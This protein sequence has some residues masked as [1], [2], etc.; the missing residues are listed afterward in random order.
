MYSFHLNA[1]SWILR[2]CSGDLGIPR[3][4]CDILRLTASGKGTPQ[5]GDFSPFNASDLL[6]FVAS[7]CFL[8]V[9]AFIA[10]QLR[11]TQFMP[12]HAL[13]RKIYDF[14]LLQRGQ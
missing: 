1:L 12:L 13:F 9:F 14:T 7:L 2:K 3:V 5:H 10:L 8:P 4:V 6:C 11:Q